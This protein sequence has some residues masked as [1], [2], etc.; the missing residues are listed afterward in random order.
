MYKLKMSALLSQFDVSKKLSAIYKNVIEKNKK[1]TNKTMSERRHRVMK[2]V[3][4]NGFITNAIVC[5][6]LCIEEGAA[7]RVITDLTQKGILVTIGE[8]KIRR[9][10]MSTK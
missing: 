10:I 6:L 9:D 8:K 5:E 3:E 2:Y 4:E 7:K 1:T